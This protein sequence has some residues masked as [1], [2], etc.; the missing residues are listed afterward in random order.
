M[1]PPSADSDLS[2]LQPKKIINM[3]CTYV[4]LMTIFNKDNPLHD[5]AVIISLFD[6]KLY[7][8]GNTLPMDLSS[9]F[10]RPGA[11]EMLQS[12]GTRHQ[13]AYSV[14]NY[15]Q[16][17][18]TVV[19]SEEKGRVSLFD[20]GVIQIGVTKNRLHEELLKKVEYNQVTLE[21]LVQVLFVFHAFEIEK[22]ICFF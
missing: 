8:A 20:R 21:Q 3:H 22:L 7:S 17:T 15:A 18:L 16:K 5:G 19:V 1:F 4:S 11:A 6:G 9:F 10:I 14:S 2:M 12:V 13:S